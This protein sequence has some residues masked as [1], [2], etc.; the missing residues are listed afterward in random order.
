M[1]VLGQNSKYRGQGLGEVQVR[2][3]I[4]GQVCKRMKV[5]MSI[6]VK[7]I[8]VR[9]QQ[10]REKGQ[11]SDSCLVHELGKYQSRKAEP[12]HT[13]QAGI[14]SSDTTSFPESIHLRCV[15]LIL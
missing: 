6:K 15:S 2:N 4:Q 5:W 9:G 13:R 8:G 10:Q 11:E 12:S 7:S 1:R 14:Q 3:I